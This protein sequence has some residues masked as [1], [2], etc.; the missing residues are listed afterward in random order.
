MQISSAFGS[1][2]FLATALTASLI[3]AWAMTSAARS[4][5]AGDAADRPRALLAEA[6]RRRLVKNYGKPRK[7]A[8][9]KGCSPR[10]AAAGRRVALLLAAFTAAAIFVFAVEISRQSAMRKAVASAEHYAEKVAAETALEI[11]KYFDEEYTA[12]GNLGLNLLSVLKYGRPIRDLE[13][14]AKSMLEARHSRIAVAYEIYDRRGALRHTG[15][16]TI[17]E[18]APPRIVFADESE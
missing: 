4:P 5:L 9:P 18:D 17:S 1:P 15:G 6:G 10:N 14:F 7:A 11:E 13:R 3:D 12:A 8:R 16:E 2:F